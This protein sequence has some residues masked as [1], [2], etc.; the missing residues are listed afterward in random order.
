M[1]MMASKGTGNIRYNGGIPSFAEL[2]I[3]RMLKLLGTKGC[4]LCEEVWWTL[5]PHSVA[6][7]WQ[8]EQVD[9]AEQVDADRLIAEYGL[10]IPVLKFNNQEFSGEISVEAVQ[11]WLNQLDVGR[12]ANANS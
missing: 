5:A 9:I 12:E 10:R 11:Q 7:Q 6:M 1:Q 4:H 3:V 2:D 8:I